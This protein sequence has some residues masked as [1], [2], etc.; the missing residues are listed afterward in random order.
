MTT[1]PLTQRDWDA[2]YNAGLK[3]GRA[4]AW[5]MAMKI[6]KAA[7]GTAYITGGDTREAKTLRDICNLMLEASR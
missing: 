7:T 2:A 1:E 5:S 4:E 6:V 3:A